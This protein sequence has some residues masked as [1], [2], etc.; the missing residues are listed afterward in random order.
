MGLTCALGGRGAWCGDG[1]DGGAGAGAGA[2]DGVAS[3]VPT[4]SPACTI[5]SPSIDNRFWRAW[6]RSVIHNALSWADA[7]AI[8]KQPGSAFPGT[9]H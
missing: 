6:N 7:N 8:I 9:T 1:T 5:D 3:T 4:A 2:G